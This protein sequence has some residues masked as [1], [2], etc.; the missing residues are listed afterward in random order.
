MFRRKPMAPDEQSR[1]ELQR[2]LVEVM[3][4]D[5]AEYVM[6][7]L[8]PDEWPELATKTDLRNVGVEIR[9]DMAHEFA[10]VHRRFDAVDQRFEGVDKRFEGVDK[11]FEGVDKRFEGLDQRFDSMEQRVDVRFDA[12]DHRFDSMEQRVDVRFDAVDQRFEESARMLDVRFEAADQKSD[13]IRDEMRQGFDTC[14]RILDHRLGE[15]DANMR[16]AVA[17]ATATLR[18]EMI[19][20]TR[21]MIIALATIMVALVAALGR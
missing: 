8:P 14:Y 10:L 7:H 4:P 19:V 1:N 15:S 17:T 13:S 3:G 11:R 5:A 6:T 20:Q 2:R 12:L 21:T 9:K 18:R 16:T